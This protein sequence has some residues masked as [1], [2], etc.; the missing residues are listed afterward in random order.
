VKA[1]VQTGTRFLML[2]DFGKVIGEE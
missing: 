2:I 1:V